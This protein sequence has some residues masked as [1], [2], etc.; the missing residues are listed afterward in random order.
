M[1]ST[2]T[3]T[4]PCGVH[5]AGAHGHSDVARYADAMD[6]TSLQKAA[7]LGYAPPRA[8][9]ADV[10]AGSG[11]P[12]YDLA[13]L[14]PFATVTGL[15]LDPAMIAHARSHF[16]LPGLS[17]EVADARARFFPEAS[18][19]LV[20]FS[21]TGHHLTSYGDP[22]FDPKHVL[23]AFDA[24]AWQLA[25][26]GLLVHRDF[27]LPP[28]PDEVILELPHGDG[29]T[30]GGTE[31]L[32][33]ATFFLRFA[34][35]FRSSLH[36]T[37]G[38]PF[39]RLPDAS[40]GWHRFRLK[41][42]DAVEFLLRKDY[43]ATFEAEILE[44][45]LY[46]TREFVEA[47]LVDRDFRIL[48]SQP[49]WNPWIVE[50]RFEGKYRWSLPS[51]RPLPHPPTNFVVVAEKAKKGQGVAIEPKH[52]RV[53][54]VPKF[55]RGLVYR[56]RNTNGPFDLVSRPNRTIDLLPYAVENGRLYVYA[57]Q[58]F[59]R[60]MITLTGSLGTSSLTE[61]R[62]AGYV[63]EPIT[64][65]E[66]RDPRFEE[67]ERQLAKRGGLKP[68]DGGADDLAPWSYYPSPGISDERVDKV[69]VRVPLHHEMRLP[70]KSYSGFSTSGVVRAFDGEQIL[71]FAGIGAHLDARLELGVYDLLLDLALPVPVSLVP[72][73]LVD[74]PETPL[75]WTEVEAALLPGT[76]ERR[77]VLDRD[78]PFGNFL[79]IREGTFEEKLA[80]STD[81]VRQK[82]EYA[83]PKNSSSNVASALPFAFVGDRVAVAI[84]ARHFASVQ[85]HEGRSN[86]GVCPAWWLPKTVDG[87]AEAMAFVRGRLA[88]WT[89]DTP[90]KCFELGGAYAPSAGLSP[91]LVYPLA[92]QFDAK[93][94]RRLPWLVVDLD[95]LVKNRRKILDGHL[96]ISV[97]RLAHAL[98]RLGR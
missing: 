14:L 69:R 44:E 56:D 65:L 60:P 12:A 1:A 78:A 75:P 50:N 4:D 16:V 26:G 5:L 72:I 3:P 15:D 24:F 93:D 90:A 52:S 61:T 91:E 41:H 17:Y 83:V 94:F 8:K 54:A 81:V 64:F 48:T 43:R 7:W 71:R 82:R 23:A 88:E 35:H 53:L 42:R 21:S 27:V 87:V 47:A 74:A 2:P 89:K 77:F 22:R 66:G 70:E 49:I 32:S 37:S 63:V 67:I 45:Y 20:S 13:R 6:R 55:L 80:Q 95:E 18:L 29:T 10:G 86:L 79:E 11:K 36:P 59:P 73:P 76:P 39:E 28:G 62:R 92:V 34:H 97:L 98:G 19:D 85:R 9:L 96:A 57:R 51:G 58:G 30:D 40:D 38:V 84:E 68:L 31:S 46:G 25:P 33:T